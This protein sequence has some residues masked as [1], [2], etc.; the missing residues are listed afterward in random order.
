MHTPSR[1]SAVARQWRTT[2][3]TRLHQTNWT[4]RIKRTRAQHGSPYASVPLMPVTVLDSDL[5]ISYENKNY[6]L[7]QIAENEL[8]KEAAL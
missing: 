6:F 8:R 5:S 4:L 7:W 1:H 3:R 2:Q